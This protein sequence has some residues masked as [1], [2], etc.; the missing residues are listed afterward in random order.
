MICIIYKI[1]TCLLKIDVIMGVGENHE[2]KCLWFFS[3]IHS[4]LSA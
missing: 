3:Y 2:Q 4:K 1:K